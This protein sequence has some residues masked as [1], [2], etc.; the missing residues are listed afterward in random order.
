MINAIIYLI[1][2]LVV[3]GIVFFVFAC[4]SCWI[5]DDVVGGMAVLAVIIGIITG[6]FVDV[7]IY[8]FAKSK[9]KIEKEEI[10]YEVI[11]AS[12]L[13]EQISKSSSVP[14]IVWTDATGKSFSTELED[15]TIVVS[16]EWK[17]VQTT[18]KVTN[19]LKILYEPDD[20][21]AIYIPVEEIH[22]YSK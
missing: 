8:E 13:E 14:V 20:N 17:M 2:G 21:W 5:F 9:A 3:L 16:E 11:G 19:W 15:V 4:I 7:K 22:G 1:I 10:V 6:I 18:Y 12:L